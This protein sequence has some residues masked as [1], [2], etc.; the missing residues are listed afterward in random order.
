MEKL[1][2]LLVEHGIKP[3]FQRLKILEYLQKNDIHPTVDTIYNE[4]YKKV[5]TLSKATI[6]NTLD[7]FRRSGIVNVLTITETE[8]RYEYNNGHHHH[9]LCR[10]CGKIYDV[11]VECPY[12]MHPD[13]HGHQLEEVH[14]YFRGL[15]VDCR[16]KLAQ[17]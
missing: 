16:K 2:E 12:A 6:Y 8:L 4:L 10:E 7:I 1:K 3:T 9:F 11:D 17:K 14:S 13:L 5:P 15:C